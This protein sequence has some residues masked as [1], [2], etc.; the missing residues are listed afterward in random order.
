MFLQLF[1]TLLWDNTGRVGLGAKGQ[2]GGE[3]GEETRG[4]VISPSCPQACLGCGLQG[5]AHLA[6]LSLSRVVGRAITA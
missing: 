5:Q 3:G 6:P 4:L 1:L 2:R